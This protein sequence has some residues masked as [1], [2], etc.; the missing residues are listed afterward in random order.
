MRDMTKKR[1]V[2]SNLHQVIGFKPKKTYTCTTYVY[3]KDVHVSKGLECFNKSSGCRV[4]ATS[5]EIGGKSHFATS[6]KFI[7]ISSNDNK[8]NTG[9][10]Q[11]NKPRNVLM[12]FWASPL[13]CD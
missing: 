2:S 5:D 9:V 11:W 13:L 3:E 1:K 7:L 8:K 10:I 12:T 4:N 6:E